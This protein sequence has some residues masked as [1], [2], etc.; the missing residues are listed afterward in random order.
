MK[1]GFG[2]SEPSEERLRYAK[3]LGADGV[4]CDARA[5]PGYAA[6]GRATAEEI[7]ALK[8]TVESYGLELLVLRLAPGATAGVLYG[9]P[10]RDRE[11][12][13]ICATIRAALP[14]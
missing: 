12:E 2:I 8:R 14:R 5:M 13:D 1:I 6:N 11:I 4:G 10:Q 9:L 3:Q 7:A